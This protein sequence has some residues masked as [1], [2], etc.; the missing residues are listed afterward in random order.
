MYGCGFF[1]YDIL[2]RFCKILCEAEKTEYVEKYENI[3][4]NLKTALNEKAWDGNWFKRAFT[5]SGKELGCSQNEECK[6]DSIA[7]SWA[8]ISNACTEEKI[9]KAMQSLE[10]HLVDRNARNYQTSKSAI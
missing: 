4:Q 9:S 10:E 8:V 2:D 6:I 3:K 1:L 5:D 7:Q